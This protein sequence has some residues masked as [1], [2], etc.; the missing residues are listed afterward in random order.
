MGWTFS[1]HGKAGKFVQ[2]FQPS[3]LNG[4]DHLEDLGMDRR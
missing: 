2:N 4:R 1:R 3:N